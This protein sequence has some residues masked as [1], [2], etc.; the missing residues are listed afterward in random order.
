MK[1]TFLACLLLLSLKGSTQIIADP[2][3]SLINMVAE[4]GDAVNTA[5]LSTGVSF[6]LKIPVYNLNMINA[7]PAGSC[8]IK[9]GLGSKIDLDPNFII[10]TASI[11]P[12]FEWSASDAGGQVQ[13]VG[14]LIAPLPS[15]YL[16]TAVFQVRGNL[17]GTSTITTNFLV[18]NHNTS[19]TLSDENPTNNNASLAYVLSSV[20]PVNFIGL[21]TTKSGCT[22]NINFTTSQ[23]FNVNRYELEISKDGTAYAKANTHR[24][25]NAGRYSFNLSLSDSLKNEKIFIR[26]KSVD[27]DGKFQYST[28]KSVS[29]LCDGVA[30]ILSYPNPLLYNQ[31]LTIVNKHSFFSG[32]YRL[33][34]FSINGK[35]VQNENINLARVKQFSYKA[36]Y[37]TAGKYLLLMNKQASTE[38]FVI[39]IEKL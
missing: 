16:D 34:L 32:I 8:K 20:L 11:N 37:L 38:H 3:T 19:T 36:P 2:A 31:Q 23:E 5:S 6:R 7:I 26:I 17:P 10:A 33:S 35:L 29:G 27:N 25:V 14:N 39:E 24:A 15:N 12:H 21:N 18:T 28:V 1:N 9:I 22:I 4:N 30:G 13:I